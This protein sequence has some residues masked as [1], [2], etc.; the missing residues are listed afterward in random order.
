M[1]MEKVS[2]LDFWM[3]FDSVRNGTLEDVSKFTNIPL[4]TLKNLRTRKLLPNLADTTAIAEYLN[5]SLDWLVLGKVS[6]NMNDKLLVAYSK[7]DELTK[8][9]IH[10]LLNIF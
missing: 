10:K 5:V 9:M 2:V 3:R 1:A 4:G 6:E 8:M 7:A